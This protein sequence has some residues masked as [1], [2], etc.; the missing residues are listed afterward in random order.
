MLFAYVLVLFCEIHRMEK[1]A[2]VW[3]H[4]KGLQDWEGQMFF[5]TTEREKKEPERKNWSM[6]KVRKMKQERE[7][8]ERSGE[9]KQLQQ[10]LANPESLIV[11][12]S[13]KKQKASVWS[14]PEPG[15]HFTQTD[16]SKRATKTSK[17]SP[18]IRCLFLLH[19][20]TEACEAEKKLKLTFLSHCLPH[21]FFLKQPW[22]FKWKITVCLC[23]DLLWWSFESLIAALHQFHS[24]IW[25]IQRFPP[26]VHQRPLVCSAP[27]FICEWW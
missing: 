15:W 14:L 17:P 18:L 6:R 22:L 20:Y 13:W 3:K 9:E 19:S 21:N 16:E 4:K 23:S 10:L 11:S 8:E 25:N 7:L 26:W 12:S 2:T 24:A 5:T 27:C 1:R